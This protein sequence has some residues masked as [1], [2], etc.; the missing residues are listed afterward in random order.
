[1][2]SAIALL[3]SLYILAYAGNPGLNYTVEP[4]W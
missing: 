2:E 1:M 4:I 3:V